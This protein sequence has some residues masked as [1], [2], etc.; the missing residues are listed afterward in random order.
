NGVEG[1]VDTSPAGLAT[2]TTRGND[3]STLRRDADGTLTE[4]VP[5]ADP[6]WG[7]LA[8]IASSLVMTTPAGLRASLA[9]TRT[10]TLTD[11]HNPFSLVTLTEINTLNR[12]P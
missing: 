2:V 6:R 11:T 7:M 3:G 10:A 9:T 1:R 12:R 5:G 4:M 8:P